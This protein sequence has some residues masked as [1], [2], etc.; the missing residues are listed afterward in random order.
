[1]DLAD[2][3]VLSSNGARARDFLL[4]GPVYFFFFFGFFTSFFGLLSLAT[5]VILP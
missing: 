1:M 2:A 4:R 5:C 3:Y